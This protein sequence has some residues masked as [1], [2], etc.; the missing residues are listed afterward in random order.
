MYP[1]TLIRIS[2]NKKLKLE[3]KNGDLYEGTCIKCDL[4][5]NLYMTNVKVLSGSDK[6]SYTE[7]F[8]KGAHIKYF[9]VPK[10][11]MDVQEKTKKNKD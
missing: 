11:L 9:D 1:L 10:S 7:C 2:K 3:L 6:Y 8:I 4:Y 5:M